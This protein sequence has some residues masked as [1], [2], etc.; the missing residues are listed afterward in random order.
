MKIKHEKSKYFILFRYMKQYE[1]IVLLIF[2]LRSFMIIFHLEEKN[3]VKIKEENKKM[4]YEDEVT[5]EY[6]V[7]FEKRKKG[8]KISILSDP[9]FKAM[10]YQENRIKY[11]CK[12]LSYFLDISYEKLLEILKLGKGELDKNK[13]IEK[14]ERSDYVAYIDHTAINIEVNCNDNILSLERNME[15]AHRLYSREVKRGSK[16]LYTQVIQFNLNN[17]A[18]KNNPKIVDYY[19]VQND[20][21]NLLHDKLIFV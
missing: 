21:K 11:S 4:L 15:Y 10:F 3:M 13:E 16:Y 6:S 9:M 19:Y 20:E 12:F 2:P 18:F 17:F 7:K 8:M 1:F 14:A 5:K